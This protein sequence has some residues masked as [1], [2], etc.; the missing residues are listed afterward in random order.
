MRANSLEYEHYLL[1]LSSSFSCPAFHTNTLLPIIQ[2]VSSKTMIRYAK[3]RAPN[4]CYF[5]K[6]NNISIEKNCRLRGAV[7]LPTRAQDQNVLRWKVT[8]APQGRLSLNWRVWAIEWFQI[9]DGRALRVDKGGKVLFVRDHE[10]I[11]SVTLGLEEDKKVGGRQ[12][13]C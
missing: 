8:S 11:K 5:C 7:I 6:H 3:L 2:P 13:I 4:E 1:I 9:D 12:G 10:G